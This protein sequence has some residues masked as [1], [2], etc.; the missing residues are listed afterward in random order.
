M[1]YVYQ[2]SAQESTKE[3]PLYGK[4]SKQPTEE[5]LSSPTTPYMEDLD[6][7]KSDLVCGL[8]KA[9]K[10]A[11]QCIEGAQWHQKAQYDLR[12]EMDYHVGDRVMVHMPHESTGNLPDTTLDHTRSI[13]SPHQMWRYACMADKPEDPSVF[14]ILFH[15]SYIEM[16]LYSI[17]R[18]G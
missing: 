17:T 6:D 1:L 2:V 13:V 18:T 16:P 11:K 15:S 9:W 7:Y 10:T 12:A 3:S 8:S 5:A 14:C 4:D